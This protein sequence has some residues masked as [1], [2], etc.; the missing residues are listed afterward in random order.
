MS[1]AHH[2]T[3]GRRRL[4]RSLEDFGDFRIVCVFV[5]VSQHPT[6]LDPKLPC[7]SQRRHNYSWSIWR[8][9]KLPLGGF[10]SVLLEW[11]SRK[12]SQKIS[13]KQQDRMAVRLEAAASPFLAMCVA[14]VRRL[15]RMQTTER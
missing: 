4:L 15:I 1:R 10:W 8:L 12:M 9:Q 6:K 3:L 13:G 14:V 5:P 7:V 2:P 11:L